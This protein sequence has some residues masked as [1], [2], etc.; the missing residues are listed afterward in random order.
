MRRILVRD[1]YD[2]NNHLLEDRCVLC[3]EEDGRIINP[4]KSTLKT[5]IGKE[6][7]EL[8]KQYGIKGEGEIK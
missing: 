1:V 6:R 3:V 5:D 4:L 8:E 7:A 2:Q